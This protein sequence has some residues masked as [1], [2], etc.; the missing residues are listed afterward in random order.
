MMHFVISLFNN[1]PITLE[2]MSWAVEILSIL[3]DQLG[4]V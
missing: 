4:H 3:I 2:K 1:K